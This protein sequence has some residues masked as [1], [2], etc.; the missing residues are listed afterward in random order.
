MASGALDWTRQFIK[1]G[2]SFPDVLSS[3]WELRWPVPRTV[4]RAIG[5]SSSFNWML[6]IPTLGQMWM[7]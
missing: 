2:Q 4:L 3:S 5:A 6:R 7:S 1:V